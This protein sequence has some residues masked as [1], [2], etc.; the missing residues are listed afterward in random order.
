NQRLWGYISHSVFTMLV[1]ILIL[2]YGIY[3]SFGIFF[4]GLV[5][6]V[7]LSV[8]T[9]MT[10]TYNEPLLGRNMTG[11][12]SD[13]YDSVL[14]STS[15]LAMDAQIEAN[16]ELHTSGAI[17][18]LGL[19]LSY[20]PTNDTCLSSLGMVH[21][22]N[23]LP[24]KSILK[25]ILVYTFMISIFLYGLA[26]AM[27]N[28]FL[29]LLLSDFGLNPCLIGLTGP[30]GGLAELITFWL[31]RE[32]FDKYSVTF[33]MTMAYLSF[34]FRAI[35]YT[36]LS[37][38]ETKS[39]VAAL[40]LQ[41][42]N[43]FVYALVWSTTM[44]E[45]DVFFPANQKEVAQGISAILFSG[46]SYGIASVLGGFIYDIYGPLKLFQISAFICSVSLI[47]FL[48]GRRPIS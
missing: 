18:P 17:P 5:I 12:P 13:R 32:L 25:T 11:K 42:L 23:Q 33:L 1:G 16:N 41:L 19:V 27:I 2:K 45:M 37:S 15:S 6:F 35:V 47:V 22:A 38:Y 3:V 9:H 44:F 8:F 21:Q 30:I 29:F 36:C 24:E 4:V 46:I 34:I 28:Q 40:I 48:S 10:T 20:I 14:Y 26:H 31:S 39:I 7:I 43:G